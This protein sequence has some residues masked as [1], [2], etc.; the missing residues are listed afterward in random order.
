MCNTAAVSSPLAT[1]LQ[2]YHIPTTFFPNQEFCL[3]PLVPVSLISWPLACLWP[4]GW[5]LTGLWTCV[6]C[7]QIMCAL[8]LPQL[9][10]E[11]VFPFGIKAEWPGAVHE[12]RVYVRFLEFTS[13]VFLCDVALRPT[14]IKVNFHW[15]IPLSVTFGSKH[16]LWPLPSHKLNSTVIGSSLPIAISLG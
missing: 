15:S 6:L 9:D 16:K 3:S 12:T 4:C 1:P 2:P 14:E 5:S 13:Q 10:N 11:P 8:T 7:C